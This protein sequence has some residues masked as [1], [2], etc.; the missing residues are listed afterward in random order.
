[1]ERQIVVTGKGK[2]KIHP[3]KTRVE[4]DIITLEE[5]YSDCV[6]CHNKKM[7]TI[8]EGLCS[9]G[10]NK[11]DIVTTSFNVKSKYERCYDEKSESYKSEFI[12][13]ENSQG[14]KIEFDRDSNL[15]RVVL[16]KISESNVNPIIN[17]SFFISDEDSVKDLLLERAVIDSKKKAEIMSKAAETKLGRII[18]INYSWGTVKFTSRRY[19]ISLN[20]RIYGLCDYED[21]EP[22]LAE[23]FIGS[24]PDIQPEDIDIDDTVTI[25]WSIED[26]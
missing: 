23:K 21:D 6:E 13:Y 11:E 4:L 25:A 12:G 8:M 2:L 3:D 17:L 18:E 10:F 5:K 7:Q 9:I 22:V 24:A 26:L 19:N 14:V 15:L 16:G 1:M 20:D